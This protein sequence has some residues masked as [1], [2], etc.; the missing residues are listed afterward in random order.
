MKHIKLLEA[1]ADIAY[2]FGSQGYFSGDSRADI[3]EII[4]LAIKFEKSHE[5][6]NW[7]TASDYIETITNYA[8]HAFNEATEKGSADSRALITIIRDK[9]AYGDKKKKDNS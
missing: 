7:D 5:N 4:L 6:E 9:R 1:V 8:L 3:A 2:I